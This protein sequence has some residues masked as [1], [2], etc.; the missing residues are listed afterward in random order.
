MQ[1]RYM[2]LFNRCKESSPC[3]TASRFPFASTCIRAFSQPIYFPPIQWGTVLTY[4][5]VHSITIY[6]V[7]PPFQLLSLGE[8]FREVTFGQ[9]ALLS[10]FS[11]TC[12]FNTRLVNRKVND[13]S[14]IFALLAILPS[15]GSDMPPRWAGPYCH[16]FH[17]FIPLLLMLGPAFC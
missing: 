17:S 14:A 12:I 8:Y 6:F 13:S 11:I 7:M 15:I 1:A 16:S 5:T 9:H 4:L 10:I 3:Q 2:R